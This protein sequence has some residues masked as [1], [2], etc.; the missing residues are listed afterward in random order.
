[1]FGARPQHVASDRQDHSP[2]D[3][4]RCTATKLAGSVSSGRSTGGGEARPQ[5]QPHA[6]CGL[7]SARAARVPRQR[8]RDAIGRNIVG[9]GLL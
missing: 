2:P 3:L 7:C 6:R 4:R 8:G 1:M 9:H 5:A